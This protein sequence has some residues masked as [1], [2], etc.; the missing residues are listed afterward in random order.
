MIQH[1]NNNLKEE[2]TED[3]DIFSSK[4]ADTDYMSEL[5]I[6]FVWF[7][8]RNDIPCRRKNNQ[9]HNKMLESYEFYIHE[10]RRKKKK[11]S[12]L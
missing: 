6:Y 4:E 5:G 11:L 10:Y 3:K 7:S 2:N 9:F 12:S 1:F 8:Q